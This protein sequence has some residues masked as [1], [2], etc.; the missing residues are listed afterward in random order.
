MIG[1]T[2]IKVSEVGVEGTGYAISTKQALPVID[3]LVRVGYAIRPWIGV[4]L[5]TVDQ[6]VILRYRLGVNQGALVTQVA[7]GSP[8]DKAGIKAGDVITS[9]DGKDITTVDDLNTI[10]H[11]YNIGQQVSI[12]YY[13]GSTSAI[14]SL[15]LASSP[16]SS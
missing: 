15:T 14:V 12:T 2:S 6:L 3:D 10:L 8:A 4:N 5:Y 16:P 7:S 11:G 1:I 13:R 9:I